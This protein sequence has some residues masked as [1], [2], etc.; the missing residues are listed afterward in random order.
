MALIAVLRRDRDRSKFVDPLVHSHHSWQPALVYDYRC[1]WSV[2]ELRLRGQ[3]R[4]RM[5]TSPDTLAHT[6]SARKVGAGDGRGCGVKKPPCER[7]L[8]VVACLIA[9]RFASSARAQV[10]MACGEGTDIHN[11]H[12]GCG[13]DPQPPTR[14]HDL[15]GC[16]SSDATTAF[17]L[18]TRCV[19]RWR[20]AVGAVMPHLRCASPM[21]RCWSVPGIGSS[22][23]FA[24][25]RCPT[26]SPNDHQ[27][28][29][30]AAVS[31]RPAHRPAVD[32]RVNDR[33]LECRG[34]S[35]FHLMPC[36]A[37][38]TLHHAQHPT[39]PL[40]HPGAEGAAHPCGR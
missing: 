39:V 27:V 21:A 17:P 16:R 31:G 10:R 25:Q 4:R 7:G 9:C 14:P 2:V 5:G 33:A 13:C 23:H 3:G 11:P 34:A 19:T 24:Y 18:A 8:G 36:A 15:Y 1:R 38:P 20:D 28:D 26:S 22:H 37:M 29:T 40:R 30:T 12:A 6:R 32:I 35:P